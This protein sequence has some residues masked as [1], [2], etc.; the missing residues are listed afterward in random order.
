M[1]DRKR[2][3]VMLLGVVPL[4]VLAGCGYSHRTLLRE[5]IGTINVP[6]FDNH[7]WYRGLEAEL[8]KRMVEEVELHTQLHFAPRDEADS[9]L[10]GAL[11]DYYQDVGAKR[12]DDDVLL[13]RVTATVRFRW[14]DRLTGREIVPWQT[15]RESAL[16]VLALG[17]PP[18]DRVLRRLAERV[19]EKRRQPW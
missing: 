14:V 5:D 12:T 10:E 19:V 6:V 18:E 3:Y 15:M 8:T 17:E 7:T 13:A 1:S 16:N 2:R 9:V 4:L 11:V